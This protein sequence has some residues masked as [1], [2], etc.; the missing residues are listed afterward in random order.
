[1]D[2]PATVAWQYVARVVFPEDLPMAAARLLAAGYDS[3]SLCELAGLSRRAE[4]AAIDELFDGAMEELGIRVP[5]DEIAGR[6]LMH[7]IAAQLCA[8]VL[9][10]RD[11]AARVWRGIA[12]LTEAE[13]EFVRAVG[14]EYHLDYLSPDGLRAWE[15]AV[16]T[17][18]RTLAQTAFPVA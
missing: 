7:H 8:G 18:A 13:C 12:S 3:P 17:A 16:R 2:Q 14:E 4:T 9:S 15:N 11:A 10:P 6:C 1:M 5:D